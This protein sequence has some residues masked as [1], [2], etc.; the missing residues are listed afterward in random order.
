MSTYLTRQDE[1]NY[2]HELLDVTK[3]AALDVVVPHIQHLEAQNNALQ[4]RLQREQRRRLDNEVAAAVPDFR[5][6]DRDPR[7]HRWLASPDPLTGR[8]RQTFLNDAIAQG[9]GARVRAFF[10]TFKAAAGTP[11]AAASG[12]GRPSG[13]KP[14]YTRASIAQIYELRRKGG[15]SDADWARLEADIFAAQH[16]G[17]IQATPYLTK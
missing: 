2:G 8:P 5:E 13:N 15:Y 9:D 17:R 3:R 7:W 1:E 4:Q 10:N 16:E 6:V 14:V 12:W 11:Q